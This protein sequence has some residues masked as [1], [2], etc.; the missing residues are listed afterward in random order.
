M[1]PESTDYHNQTFVY[2]LCPYVHG[3]KVNSVLVRVCTLEHGVPSCSNM[4]IDHP[5]PELRLY[6]SKRMNGTKTHDSKVVGKL[7]HILTT[8][9][10]PSPCLNSISTLLPTLQPLRWLV[11]P[12]QEADSTCIPLRIKPLQILLVD[13]RQNW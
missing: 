5:N 4:S 3:F 8:T 13:H 1:A 10:Q 9:P 12:F 6:K 7:Q 2:V 11:S